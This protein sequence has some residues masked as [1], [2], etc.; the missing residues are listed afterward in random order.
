MGS[1]LR[2]GV[3]QFGSTHDKN[4]NLQLIKS[5]V[6]RGC[7]ADLVVLPEY[8]MATLT[9]L[10]P[11]DLRRIAEDLDGPFVRGL[12]EVAREC[13]SYLV[14][15]VFERGEGKGVYNTAVIISPDGEVVGRYR[16]VH[17]FDAYGYRESDFF[18]RGEEL[19][20]VIDAGKF[21]LGVAVCF[22]IR[23]PELFRYLALKGADLIA[24]PSAWFKGP[25]KEE[26]LHFLG[27]ARA[28]EN[29]LYVVIA[30][31]FGEYFVGRSAVIDPYGTLIADL[32][33]GVKYVEVEV[34][35]G[36]IS[37]VREKVPVLKLR[38]PDLYGEFG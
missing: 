14:A 30:D 28:H 8:S 27:R 7:G 15:G 24:L 31:Q 32:G 25:L 37:E 3:L 18:E 2:V 20:P 6:V 36:L 12:S 17:L 13:S 19:P 9:G 11:E 29:T 5:R 10:S 35:L 21:K 22:D 38:R 34:D 33:V 4:E 26:T 1:S 16:K 23:F